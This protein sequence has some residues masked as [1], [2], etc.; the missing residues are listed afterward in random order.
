MSDAIYVS[1]CRRY[2]DS[3]VNALCRTDDV[4]GRLAAGRRRG[5]G[6]GHTGIWV[7]GR[8]VDSGELLRWR[9]IHM[10]NSFF[11][12]LALVGSLQARLRSVFEG[13]RICRRSSYVV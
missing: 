13:R 9:G 4:Q 2:D 6:I 11:N 12:S 5:E 1:K 7:V 10:P 3:A 8:P